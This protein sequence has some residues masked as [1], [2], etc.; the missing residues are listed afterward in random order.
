MIQLNLLPDVKLEY[1]KA[2]KLRS[3]VMSISVIVTSLAIVILV[4][5]LIFDFAQKAHINNLKNTITTYS[6]ELKNKPNIGTILTVQNQLKSLT[7]L[8]TSRPAAARL[9]DTYLNEVTPETVSLNQMDADFTQNT[10][11]LTGTTDSLTTVNQYVD[12]L[13]LTSY[14]I[15]G[16]SA[17]APAFTNVVLSSFGI[18]SQA[19]NPSQA[20]NFTIDLDFAPQ[21]FD[22]ASNTTLTVPNITVTHSDQQD[23]G[24]LFKAAPTSSK[25]GGQ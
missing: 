3:L 24:S 21:I 20:A 6:N 2:Q 14:S 5:F 10:L 1:I 22:I 17:N 4:L 15:S 16:S 9:F 23:T 12:T 13:K 7:N 8:Y 11:I 25:T 19:P 18:N